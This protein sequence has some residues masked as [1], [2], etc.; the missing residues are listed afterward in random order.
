MTDALADFVVSACEIA[1]TVTVAG[2]GTAEGAAYSPAAVTVPMVEFPPTTPFTCHVTAVLLVPP[3]E[4]VNCCV[5]EVGTLALTG[6]TA[7]VTTVA[8]VTVTAAEADFVVSAC[9]MAFTVTV[10]GLGTVVGAVYNPAVE[11][12]PVVVFPPVTLFT[13]QV[14]AVLED[15]VTV[16]VNCCV[17]V[18]C[19][20]ADVGDTETLT[21]TAA[22]TVTVAEADLVVSA[23]EIAFTVTVAGLGTVAGAV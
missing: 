1:V 3:T 7:T 14:T 11:I 8:A 10:A 19:T 18:V 9:E 6:D 13:C 5:P 22:V 4:A 15:P 2:V 17:A 20:E 23:C 16:A 21:A 12:V